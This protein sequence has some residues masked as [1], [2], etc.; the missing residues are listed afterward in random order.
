MGWIGKST[1]RVV[2]A[3]GRGLY[4]FQKWS[5]FIKAHIRCLSF[6]YKYAKLSFFYIKIVF[7]FFYK[8][9]AFSQNSSFIEGKRLVL[10]N[11]TL[12]M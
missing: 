11:V 2:Y 6:F 5:F 10:T 12:S 3:G 7:F 9:C 1:R 4:Y 8:K